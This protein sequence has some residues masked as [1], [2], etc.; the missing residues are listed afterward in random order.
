MTHAIG[1]LRRTFLLSA[2]AIAAAACTN[3][4]TPTATPA[5]TP[6]TTP[7]A[8]VA[9][10]ACSPLD[11]ALTGGAWGAAAGSRGADV[12]VENRGSAACTLPAGPTVAILD[13]AGTQL[14]Q[15]P[16]AT[17]EA[18]P[19]LEPGSVATFTVLFSNWC[20]EAT[21]LPLHVV[22]RDGAAGIPVP[23][24]DLTAD[25]LP[26]CNGPGQPPAL[27]ANPWQPVSG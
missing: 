2:L 19:L 9:G 8:A 10:G 7:S 14:L 11:L 21:T 26:P 25:D 16:P 23:G 13:D 20:D 3:T 12:S 24:L 22:L 4:T 27:S 6:D 17:D 1:A 15:S 18:G 5:G